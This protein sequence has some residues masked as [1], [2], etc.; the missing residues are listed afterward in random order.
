MY[1]EWEAIKEVRGLSNDAR[2]HLQH[3]WGNTLQV[4]KG[5]AEIKD[6]EMIH[7]AIDEMIG[8]LKKLGLRD[9]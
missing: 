2:Y 6:M 7:N 3:L 5:G 1:D 4:I 9:I 8:E